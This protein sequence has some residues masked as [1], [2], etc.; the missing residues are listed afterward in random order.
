MRTVLLAIVM[1][2]IGLSVGVALGAGPWTV[3]DETSAGSAGGRPSATATAKAVASYPTGLRMRAFGR[4]LKLNGD[5]HCVYDRRKV[6]SGQ[7]VVLTMADANECYVTAF[8]SASTGGFVRV[9]IEG[10]N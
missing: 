8:A 5:F 9:Q 3:L 6:S 2:T 10:R 1:L 4:N 7:A